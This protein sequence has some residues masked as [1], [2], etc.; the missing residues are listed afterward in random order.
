MASLDDY[1][2]TIKGMQS[3][4]VRWMK[5]PAPQRGEIMR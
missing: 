1:E 5:T 3:E 4:K 2:A